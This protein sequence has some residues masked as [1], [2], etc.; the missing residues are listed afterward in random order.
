MKDLVSL[1][2]KDGQRELD[3]LNSVIMSSEGKSA[4]NQERFF[5]IQYIHRWISIDKL[6]I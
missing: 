3:Q 1:D 4:L 2:A 5:C 6:D